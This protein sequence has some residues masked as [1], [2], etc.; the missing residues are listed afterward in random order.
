MTSVVAREIYWAG[1]PSGHHPTIYSTLPINRDGAGEVGQYST[2][3]TTH[4]A[5]VDT[6]EA[7]LIT[8]RASPL[9][10]YC[11]LM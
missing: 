10:A 3:F 9:P 6:D 11:M 1:V 5:A 2:V 4:Y 7:D 8:A